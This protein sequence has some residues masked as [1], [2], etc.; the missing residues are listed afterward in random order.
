MLTRSVSVGQHHVDPTEPR[1][2]ASTDPTLATHKFFLFET[3]RYRAGARCGYRKTP[4]VFRTRGPRPHS[5]RT[6]LHGCWCIRSPRST[7]A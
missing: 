6:F 2:I 7:R 3:R 5:H 4:F 1:T